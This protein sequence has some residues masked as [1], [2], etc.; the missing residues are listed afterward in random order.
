MN[1]DRIVELVLSRI[2]LTVAGSTVLLTSAFVGLAVI[3]EGRIVSGVTTR[4]PFYV[5]VFS[6]AFIVALL[7]LDNRD[8]DGTQILI[9]T[10]GIGLGAGSLFGLATEGIAYTLYEPEAV[11]QTG[12]AVVFLAAGII[13]TG[14]GIWGVRHWREFVGT[15]PRYP[16]NEET[17]LEPME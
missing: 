9:A 6:L 8:R 11:F 7:K 10:T 2:F 4:L 1:T 14:L 3:W 15:N 5:L 13:C 16:T 17:D 12:L